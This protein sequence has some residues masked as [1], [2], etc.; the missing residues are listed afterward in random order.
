MKK[1]VFIFLGVI[2][3]F[4]A[5]GQVTDTLG[6]S[7]YTMGNETLYESPNGGFAFGVNGYGDKAK[8][9]EFSLDQSFVL[10]DV[11]LKFGAVEFNSGD[12]SSS[13]MV[14]I[15]NWGG[16]GVTMF[17]ASDSVAPDSIVASVEIPV[18]ELTDDGSYSIADFS[19][20]SIVFQANE[21]FFVSVEFGSVAVGDTLG[22]FSTSDGDGEEAYNSWELTAANSW[23][24]IAQ[25]AFSWNLDLDLA[26]FPRV[27]V[28]DPAGLESI[29]V[30]ELVSVYPNPCAEFLEVK[31]VDRKF[32]SGRLDIYSSTGQL[33]TSQVI[34]PQGNRI[35]FRA[36]SSGIYSIVLHSDNFKASTRVIKAD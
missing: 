28:N 31:Q 15:Y 22:L 19:S 20:E 18:Y 25:T 2:I 36:L 12:S 26:I 1:I 23:V 6:Y 24:V 7:K 33:I 4:V 13:V 34:N 21:R 32:D 16:P 5:N 27:D 9:Q 11:M 35:D 30:S 10:R 3:E 14:N 8:A 29:D 17:S